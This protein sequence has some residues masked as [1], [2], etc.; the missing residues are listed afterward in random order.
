M[1]FVSVNL[2]KAYDSVLT[3]NLSESLEKSNISITL[4][5]KVRLLYAGSISKIKMGN[6]TATNVV[7]T[8]LC[9]K[10]LGTLF[11]TYPECVLRTWKGKCQGMAVP[12]EDTSVHSHNLK[13]IKY[14]Q[15]KISMLLNIWQE[16]LW[17]YMRN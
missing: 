15:F 2:A 1:H 11:K 17:M 3:C 14:L 16:N 7:V 5:C 8:K 4:I 10:K 13:V 6:E 12:V 9:Q